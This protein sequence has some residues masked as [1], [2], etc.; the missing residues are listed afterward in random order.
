MTN[1]YKVLVAS[2]LAI[3]FSFSAK[4]DI[5]VTLKVDDA[6]RLTGYIQYTDAEYNYIQTDLD[7]TQFTADEGGTFT[8][9][10]SYGYVYINATDGNTITSAIDQISGNSGG[11]GSSAYFYLY[12]DANIIVTS[13]D[14]ES[15][16]TAT[17][18]VTVD[19]SSKVSLSYNTG[20]RV[21]LENGTNT[22]KFN[23]NNE[24]PFQISHTNYG[25]TL[26]SVTLNGNNVTDSYGRYYVTVADG[27]ALDIK[28]EFPDEPSI[29][30]FTYGDNEAEVLGCLS[31]K[32]NDAPVED[33]NGKTLN[34]KLG[35]KITLIGNTDLYNFNYS[36]NIDGQSTYFYGSCD[37][38]ATKTT[39][40]IEVNATK[41]ATYDVNVT[42]DNTD[43]I[44]IYAGT[45]NTPSSIISG[46]V[47]A[48]ALSSSSNYINVMPATDCYIASILVNG[49]EYS[50]NYGTQSCTVR[51]L[52]EGD[53]VVI[54]SGKV[55]R[56][57]TAT[58]WVDD[59]NAAMYGYSVQRY[60]D[61]ASVTLISGEAIT[62]NF[63]DADNPYY[64]S[65]YQPSFC[66]FFMNGVNVAPQYEGSTSYYVTFADGDALEVYLASEPEKFAVTFTQ[67]IEN[68][69]ASVSTN[70]QV[71]TNWA[72]GFSA[73][74][75]TEV[76]VALAN[77]SS[78]KVLV[79]DVNVTANENGVYVIE[80]NKDT[81]I[82]ISDE[83]SG[84]ENITVDKANTNVYNLQGM[85]IIR[86]ANIE[87]INTLPSGIYIINGKKIIR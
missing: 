83:T 26:Y 3:A 41:Y 36:I 9:P 38:V 59:L 62:I 13:A 10:S 80:I 77:E 4:A 21:S 25:E 67:N 86:N 6:T 31:V 46:E 49:N 69:V 17:C 27:D 47:T 35:D 42:V 37:F 20:E 53:N 22:I 33:F 34:A 75:G 48:I 58:I 7:L 72:N 43:Q 32:I 50:S 51:N 56:N 8:I 39:H 16:R 19:N 64:I 11:T 71:Y 29:I 40:S 15:T 84:I 82:V 63:D 30:S 14:L 87:Q 65:F 28:A 18:L 70:D 45:S 66:S 81:N 61:R 5:N 23:P 68:A 24:T 85:L 52:N 74:S 79:D 78:A 1:C 44:S 60:S 76:S 2:L 73:I 12:A 57:N 55:E 54:T